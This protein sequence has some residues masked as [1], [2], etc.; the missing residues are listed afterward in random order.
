MGL[1]SF[2]EVSLAQ[3]ARDAREL[4]REGINPIEAKKAAKRAA[5][6]AA[7]SAATITFGECA[8]QYIDAKSPESS[9]AKHLGQWRTTIE[10]FAGPSSAN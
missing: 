10:T 6:A 5:A 2:P 4:V 8:A 3:K 9:N 7:K 1:G